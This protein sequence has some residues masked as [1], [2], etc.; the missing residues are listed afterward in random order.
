MQDRIST[1]SEA[2]EYIGAFR[3]GHVANLFLVGPPGVQKTMTALKRLP[4]AHYIAGH[5]TAFQLY[6][7]CYGHRQDLSVV[8]ITDISGVPAKKGS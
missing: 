6:L 2:E 8:E 5:V 3:Q 4:E 1:Y 7:E